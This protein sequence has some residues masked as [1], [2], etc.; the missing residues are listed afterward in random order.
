MPQD[1]SYSIRPTLYYNR[2]D[3]LTNGYDDD[4]YD[5]QAR[6]GA[7]REDATTDVFGAGVLGSMRFDNAAL[8]SAS[9]SGR[10]ESWESSGFTV[11][12]SAGG[13]GGRR[14]RR[15]RR[16]WRRRRHSYGRQSDRPGRIDRPRILWTSKASCR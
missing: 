8:L 9:L 7:F 10:H 14:G 2:D 5:T 11:T 12:T 6:S 1:E 16:R 3:E 13:G 4:G 15:R